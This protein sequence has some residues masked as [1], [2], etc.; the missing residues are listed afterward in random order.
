MAGHEKGLA[1]WFGREFMGLDV[2]GELFNV[3]GA[4]LLS[5][6]GM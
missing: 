3:I 2:V 6:A 5:Q 4:F 1:G